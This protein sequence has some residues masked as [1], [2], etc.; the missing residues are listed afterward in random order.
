MSAMDGN[1]S[2]SQNV[3]KP[4]FLDNKPKDG[5]GIVGVISKE[6]VAYDI[7]YSLR[8]LQHRGQESAGIAV[9]NK[10]IECHKGMGL[11]YEAM[12]NEQMGTLKGN[13]GIGHVRYSTAGSST[14]ENSQPVV[15]KTDVGEIALAHNGEIVNA[16][17]LRKG[18]QKKGWAFATTTDSEIIIRLLANEI[19]TTRDVIKAIKSLMGKLVGS[20]SLVVL[21]ED[22]LIA[23]RDPFAFK[24]LCIGKFKNG[25]MVSSESV[26]FDTLGGTFMRDLKPVELMGDSIRP[27]MTS[28]PKNL[29]HCMF[30]WVYFARP[31]SVIEGRLVYDVRREIG[32]TLAKEHPVEADVVIPVPD[33]GRAHAL[34]YYEGS[35]IPY[36]EGLMKNRYIERTFIMPQQ[37]DREMSVILKLNPIRPVVDNK[38]VVLADDSIVRGT[39][40]RKIVQL[41]RNAGAKEVHVRIGSPPI[42]AP[43]YFGIDM[44]TRDQFAATDRTVE[45]IAELI[46]ADTLGYI[47]LEGL[48]KAIGRPS[49]DLC[50]GCLTGEYPIRIPG[51]K[52]RFQKQID[53]F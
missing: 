11:V 2:L 29:A 27:T 46:T 43:C 1:F 3:E 16:D 53:V 37:E 25:Y 23:V 48:I 51:E 33:S 17:T 36:G 12:S 45:Q 10:G 30:E 50:L 32:K 40:M 52:V 38:R 9:F 22:R 19:S 31:D 14:F 21:I 24:P 7:R 41:L 42:R 15:V 47:S 8:I 34:G 26:V 35:G 13:V 5:C 18:L 28:S 4:A 49:K 44:K 6:S 39:T 20:Y